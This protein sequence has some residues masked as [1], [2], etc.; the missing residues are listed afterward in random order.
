MKNFSAG[1]RHLAAGGAAFSTGAGSPA[2]ALLVKV[3]LS[4]ISRGLR[5]IHEAAN[6][7]Q[8][9][10][11]RNILGLLPMGQEFDDPGEPTL[12]EFASEKWQEFLDLPA[13]P[14]P[15]LEKWL[16]ELFAVSPDEDGSSR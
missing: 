8:G 6:D 7:K 10:S 12:G 2:G 16:K 15:V 3:G 1:I 5:Q 4:I 11:P 14:G 13:D 9:P